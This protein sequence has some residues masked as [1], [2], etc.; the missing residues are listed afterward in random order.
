MTVEQTLVLLVEDDAAV[1]RVLR[2]MLEAHGHTVIEASTP[3]EAC[4]RFDER[5]E[6]I[7][8]LVT[9]IVMP[10]IDG[11]TLAKRLA[12]LQPRL[13]VLFMSG[14]ADLDPATLTLGDHPVGFLAKPVLGAQLAAKV[15]ELAEA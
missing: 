1:R 6:H 15:R 2:L 5:A 9:D 14:Y 11:P 7:R 10:G 3:E 8:V 13:A 12:A 4:A